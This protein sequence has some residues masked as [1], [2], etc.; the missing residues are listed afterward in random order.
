MKTPVHQ[1]DIISRLKIEPTHWK[2]HLQ[3]MLN[4]GLTL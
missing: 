1:R 3:Y 4:K 2:K